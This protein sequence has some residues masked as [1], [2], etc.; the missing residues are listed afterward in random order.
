MTSTSHC[1]WRAKASPCYDTAQTR[2]ALL[3]ALLKSPA[4]TG[5]IRGVGVAVDLAISP[6]GRTVLAA[7]D[8]GSAHLID[9]PAGRST[10][11]IALQHTGT[12][13]F[14]HRGE[15]LVMVGEHSAIMDA[16][17]W[18]ELAPLETLGAIYDASF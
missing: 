11:P 18:L 16:H 17:S 13:N 10:A 1:C 8:D 7:S 14:D 4:T 15:R 9:V 5:V 2:G 6:D 12:A 3:A